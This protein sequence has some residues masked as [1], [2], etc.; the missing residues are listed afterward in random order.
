M[1][2]DFLG[3]T[4]LTAVAVVNLNAVLSALQVSRTARLALATAVGL[5]VGLQASLAT[6]GA[7]AAEFA[8]TVPILGLMVLAPV[9]VVGFAAWR[10]PA[11]RSALL[12]LPI[13]LLVGLNAGRLLGVF[14]LFLAAA[15]RLGGPF[16]QAAGWGDIAVGLLAL[17]LAAALAR[18][19]ASHAGVAAW[20]YLGAADLILAVTLGT[21]STNGFALQVISA[22]AGSAAIAQLPW[23]LIPT[24]LV[25]FYLIL[26]G[27]VFAQL[28]RARTGEAAVRTA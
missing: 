8:L 24:V 12:D 21:I 28:R 25:P 20:N 19:T 11:V 16:P 17:P 2:L 23:S 14:F 6:A 9:A 26:H 1:F 18:G 5:W 15:G 3:G 13:P 27:I 22:G 4:V 7:F 10:S